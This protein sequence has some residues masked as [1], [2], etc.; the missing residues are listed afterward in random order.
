MR[1]QGGYREVAL[2]A[3]EAGNHPARCDTLTDYARALRVCMCVCT[4]TVRVHV[5]TVQGAH[6]ST[7]CSEGRALKVVGERGR[8]IRSPLHSL[9]HRSALGRSPGRSQAS[10]AAACQE[11]CARGQSVVVKLREVEARYCS[12]FGC[13]AAPG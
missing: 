1:E 7:G 8:E 12:V 10:P 2:G 6:L 13:P 11:S 3:P 9:T 5:C 4:C